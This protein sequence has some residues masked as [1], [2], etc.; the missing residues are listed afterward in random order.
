MPILCHNIMMGILS[1]LPRSLPNANQCLSMIDIEKNWEELIS[2]D[3]QWSTLISVPDQCLNFY[4]YWSASGND[5]GSPDFVYKTCSSPVVHPCKH[6]IWHIR[7]NYVIVT[8]RCISILT[9]HS[10]SGEWVTFFNFST[11]A[12]NLL[13]DYYLYPN[14]VETPY[15]GDVT[16]K[17]PNG[18]I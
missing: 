10:I 8:E 4:Q 17:L 14:I 1:G 5:W 11:L 12:N 18:L 2:I 13:N 7:K 6:G 9:Y 16:Q 3:R 15:L